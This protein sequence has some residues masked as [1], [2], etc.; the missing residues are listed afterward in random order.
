MRSVARA[1]ELVVSGRPRDDTSQV[2][3]HSIETIVF[4]GTVS[5]NNQISGITLEP[6]GKGVVARLLNCQ[7]FLLKDFISKGILGWRSTTS[8]SSAR[9][10]KEQDVGN[11][12]ASDG[13]GGRADKDQ[14]HEVSALLVDVVFTLGSG[15]ARGS[16]G[17]A[18]LLN[19][20]A[21]RGEGSGG[22]DKSGGKKREQFH[23]CKI[24]GVVGDKKGLILVRHG[25]H[26]K[27]SLVVRLVLR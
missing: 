23:G 24:I 21:G 13:H 7:V 11:G 20:Y 17:G 22:A 4:K 15:H 16:N 19:T 10:Y 25:T 1:H 6:L 12:K 8:T 18:A 3:A 2:C 26:H 27:R 14:V 9:R 5:L